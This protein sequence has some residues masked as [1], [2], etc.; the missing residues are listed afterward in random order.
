MSQPAPDTAAPGSAAP[1]IRE[2]SRSLLTLAVPVVLTLLSVR[3]VMTPLFYQFEYHRTG[4]PEDFYGFTLEDRLNYA[5]YPIHYLLSDEDISYLADLRLPLSKC[6]GARAGAADCAM[7]NT[8]EL[9]HMRDVKALTQAAFLVG[10]LAALM[11]AAAVIFLW[12]HNRQVL[13]KALITG[14]LLTWGLLAA[15]VIGALVS[16]DTFFTGFH[17]MFFEG[18]TWRFAYSDTLI[19][20][21]PEQFWFDAA[22][23]IGGITA[24]GAGL[25]LGFAWHWKG[26]FDTPDA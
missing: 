13:R 5:P 4:F 7:Y 15:I 18:G 26:I 21:F 8:S 11:G 12:R 16:W 24:A 20:L 19:R 23:T 2:I 9:R 3:L 25:I 17:T 22:I 10:V 14:S 6:V 1:L